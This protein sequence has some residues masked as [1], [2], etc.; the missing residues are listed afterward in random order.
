MKL[1]KT[2]LLGLGAVGLMIVSE[3]FSMAKDEEDLREMVDEDLREM[4]DEAVDKKLAGMEEE[5]SD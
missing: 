4:V 3:L 1:S 2:K 5:E